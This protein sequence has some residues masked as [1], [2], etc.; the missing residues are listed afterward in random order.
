MSYV[1]IGRKMKAGIKV[2]HLKEW[3]DNAF[4]APELTVDIHLEQDDIHQSGNSNGE[5]RD[6]CLNPSCAQN[7]AMRKKKLQNIIQHFQTNSAE[8]NFSVMYEQEFYSLIMRIHQCDTC[9]CPRTVLDLAKVSF[10]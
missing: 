6:I 3:C 7:I 4:L 8:D 10:C 1:G 2:E 9:K 5:E